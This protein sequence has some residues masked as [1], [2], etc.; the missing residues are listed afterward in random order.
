M[1][2]ICYLFTPPD[3][4]AARLVVTGHMIDR[5]EGHVRFPLANASLVW[6]ALASL[7]DS[8][9]S[10]RGPL[11]LFTSATQGV[12]LL[13]ISVALFGRIPTDIFLPQAEPAF[14]QRSV[15][16]GAQGAAFQVLYQAAKATSW[17]SVHE[18]ADD[19]EP[20]RV[21]VAQEGT[22]SHYVAL[23]EQLADLLRRDSED[24]L[25]AVWDGRALET[26]G[27][28]GHMVGLALARG[29][30]C[31]MLQAG[32]VGADPRYDATQLRYTFL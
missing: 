18:P 12:D 5:W 14:L 20:S 30:P 1:P 9:Q 13:A 16:Y 8:L 31:L 26:P 25:V 24:L 4:G 22:T 29:I 28:T 19:A 2:P 10:S 3:D 6:D 32:L 7:V 11:H 17:I 21:F 23:N 15:V 27:G